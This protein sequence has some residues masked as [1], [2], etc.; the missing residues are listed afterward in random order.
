MANFNFNKVIL[1][2]RLTADPELKKT[3]NGDISVCSF[4]IAVNRRFSRANEQPQAD[5]INCVAWRQQAELLAKYFRK[6]S[7]VCVVGSIQTR[8]WTDNQGAKRYA[9]EVIVDEIQFVDSKSDGSA[10]E[11][12]PDSVPQA[13]AY[14]TLDAGETKFEEVD[15]DDLPF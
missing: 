15:D 3:Q 10:R 1:G 7:S 9:T 12:S 5:F 13:P 11:F 2:G 4:T 8:S 14:S 6:G